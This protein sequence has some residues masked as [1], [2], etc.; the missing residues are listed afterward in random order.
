M[1][2]V[3]K[4]L[5]PPHN[6]NKR[7]SRYR[8]Q[9]RGTF[10][11]LARLMAVAF[12]LL[13][14]QPVLAQTMHTLPFVTPASNT[15]QRTLVR[16]VNRSNRSGTVTIHAIDDTG[17]RRGPAQLWIGARQTKHIDSQQLEGGGGLSG[18]RGVGNGTGNWRLEL[19]TTLDIAPLAYIW[20][21]AGFITT[22]HDT[23]RSEA[24]RHRVLTFNKAPASLTWSHASVATDQSHRRQRGR[25][26]HGP[27]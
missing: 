3:K 19:E 5:T 9:Y 1:P 26:D 27:R 16:I 23:V 2:S 15:S 17:E 13:A 14:G 4:V 10:A 8:R 20:G 12:V 21:A 7:C 6:H 22:M 18:G 24:M 25:H 11:A